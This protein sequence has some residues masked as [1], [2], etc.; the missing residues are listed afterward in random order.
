MILPLFKLY[1]YQRE[2]RAALRKLHVLLLDYKDQ[3][4]FLIDTKL[5]IKYKF[6]SSKELFDTIYLGNVF[7]YKYLPGI[8]VKLIFDA[9][10][11]KIE[12]NFSHTGNDWGN[13]IYNYC[14]ALDSAIKEEYQ[15]S[16]DYRLM[17]LKDWCLI[18]ASLIAIL[19]SK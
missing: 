16:Y 15:H 7:V 9:D 14:V 13:R 11:I 6:R 1:L 4:S 17:R 5:L 12:N 19:R 8:D 3:T 18:L 10:I 2:K